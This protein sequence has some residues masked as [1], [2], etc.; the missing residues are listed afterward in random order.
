MIATDY[1]MKNV[2]RIYSKELNLLRLNRTF[3]WKMQAALLQKKAAGHEIKIV[4]EIKSC[5]ICN[6]DHAVLYCTIYE[7]PY[8]ECSSCGHIFLGYEISDES[9]IEMYRN[10]LDTVYLD[11]ELFDIRVTDIAAPKLE[12]IR[13]YA[14]VAPKLL[15]IGAGVGEIVAAADKIGWPNF[16]MFFTDR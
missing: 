10:H 9:I 4:S 8:L 3:E 2:E 13:R 14:P 12:F 1:I 16:R 15:D 5:T 7:Y 11:N 6:N